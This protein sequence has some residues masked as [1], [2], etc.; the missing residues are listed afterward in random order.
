[1]IQLKD[2]AGQIETRPEKNPLLFYCHL[3]NMLR[4]NRCQAENRPEPNKEDQ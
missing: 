4:I 2:R 3:L 1:M